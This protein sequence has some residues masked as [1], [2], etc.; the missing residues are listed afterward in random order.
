[1]KSFFLKGVFL[2]S[3]LW[4]SACAQP[5]HYWGNYEESLYLRA[6]DFSEEGQANAF[7]MLEDIIQEAEAKKARLGPGIYADYGYLLFK[8]GKAK[9]AVVYFQKEAELYPESKYLMDSV[10]S[11]IDVKERQ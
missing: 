3:I 6:T 9:K 4:L 11:R 1:M 5:I 10:I 8:Q 7:K 2:F